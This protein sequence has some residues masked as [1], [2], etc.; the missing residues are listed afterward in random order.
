MPPFRQLVLWR[1]L[2][3]NCLLALSDPR[4]P[5]DDGADDLQRLVWPPLFSLAIVSHHITIGNLL[6]S[7]IQHVHLVSASLGPSSSSSPSLLPSICK[8]FILIPYVIVSYSFALSFTLLV[9]LLGC[10]ESSG[11]RSVC[12]CEIDPKTL[13]VVGL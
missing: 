4:P 5:V 11:S 12:L 13:T 2:I 6:S 7:S 9:S 3:V 10:L 1:I 8:Q